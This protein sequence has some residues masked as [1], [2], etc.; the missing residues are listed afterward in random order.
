VTDEPLR[1]IAYRFSNEALEL[2]K[3]FVSG[4][5]D[6]GAQKAKAK[7]LREHLPTLSKQIPDAPEADRGEVNRALADAN[8]DLGY[9]LADGKVPSS[10]RLHHFIEGR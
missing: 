7:E 4:E 10:I 1:I 3:S 9:V 5:G 2:A 6:P 8:L